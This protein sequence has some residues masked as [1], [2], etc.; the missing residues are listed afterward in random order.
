MAGPG[1]FLAL[2]L[3]LV[4]PAGAETAIGLA[5]RGVDPLSALRNPSGLDVRD[6][7]G[8]PVSARLV[9]AELKAAQTKVAVQAAFASSLPQA[10]AITA[11]LE[12]LEA[13]RLA[14]R[15]DFAPD[16]LQRLFALLPTPRPQQKS[17]VRSVVLFGCWLLAA[18]L[19]RSSALSTFSCRLCSPLVLR[20]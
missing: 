11:R 17:P 8:R 12:M 4:C 16:P 1:L 7:F 13:L 20:C 15:A 2:A 19:W 18:A 3:A 14:L 10:A 6:E 5:A 9:A